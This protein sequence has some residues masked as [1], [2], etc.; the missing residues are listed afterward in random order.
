[1]RR[2]GR[3]GMSIITSALART[4][5]QAAADEASFGQGKEKGGWDEGGKRAADPVVCRR[6]GWE[7]EQ[8]KGCRTGTQQ[9]RGVC[10]GS[11]DQGRGVGGKAG[12]KVLG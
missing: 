12:L 3:P 4:Q 10:M 1:M 6:R 8:V 5:H 2:L 11:R 7:A 9:D